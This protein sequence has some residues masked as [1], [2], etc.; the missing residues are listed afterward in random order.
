MLRSVDEAIK[1]RIH[2]VH[3]QVTIP[4]E[5]RDKDLLKKLEAEWPQ[6]LGWILDGCAEWQKT[7]LAVPPQI[8]D[9]TER[10]VE[11]EDVLGAWLEENCDREGEADGKSLYDNYRKWCE[12]QGEH[13]WSRRGWS[14]AMIERGLDQR[15]TDGRRLFVGISLK[16]GAG[17]P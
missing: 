7:G 4:P 17:L 14:N 9:A 2:L 5:E 10:Y 12:Q 11:A 3:F 1:S 6:I 8:L 15:K 16:P 13:S